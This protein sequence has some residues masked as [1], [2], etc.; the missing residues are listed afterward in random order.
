MK[1]KHSKT[2]QKCEADIYFSLVFGIFLVYAVIKKVKSTIPQYE[3][4]L[5]RI[6]EG[7]PFPHSFLHLMA[8]ESLERAH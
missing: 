2:N 5:Y 7:L 8:K 3:Q 6:G 1:K 4:N